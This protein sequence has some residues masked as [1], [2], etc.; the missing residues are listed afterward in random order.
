MKDECC[1][2]IQ[3]YVVATNVT[4]VWLHMVH[5]CAVTYVEVRHFDTIILEHMN[6]GRVTPGG[7][8]SITSSS[9]YSLFG[10]KLPYGILVCIPVCSRATKTDIA[11]Y[12]VCD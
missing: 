8:D 11:V 5:N 6:S 10:P 2:T 3:P 4:T 9:R 12:E 1:E 7:V